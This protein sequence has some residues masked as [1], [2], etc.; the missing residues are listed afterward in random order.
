MNSNHWQIPGH[1]NIPILVY[2]FPSLESTNSEAKRL[3]MEDVPEWTV[4]YADL[5]TKGR[6][7][8]NRQWH[9]PAGLGLYFS[10]ILR[11]NMD[12]KLLNMINM[13]TALV[14]RE[15]LQTKLTQT[16]ARNDRPVMVKWP[17]DV[18]V[19]GKKIC[20]ILLESEVVSQTVNSL[21]LGIGINVNH[22]HQDFPAELR[23]RA[24]SLTLLTRQQWESSQLLNE[25]LPKL[26]QQ[27]ILDK[28]AG[29][30]DVIPEYQKNLAFKDQIVEVNLQNE[31]IKG[32]LKGI[33]SYGYLMLEQGDEIKTITT[34]DIGI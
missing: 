29:Y 8:F 14:I 12:L 6:G 30:K 31:R 1:T 5:Q 22:R 9:S 25:V 18:L 26:Q 24:T 28:E 32:R 27:L 13:R 23:E 2:Y 3:V 4:I 11:P 16:D 34:G 10:I 15:I 33:D 19:E 21:I 7:R 20:G 17:N